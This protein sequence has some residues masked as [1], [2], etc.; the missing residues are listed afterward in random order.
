MLREAIFVV[1]GEDQ[2]TIDDD[3]KDPVGAFDEFGLDAVLA[4]DCVRQTDGRGQVVSHPAVFDA[5]LHADDSLSV[6]WKSLADF[7]RCI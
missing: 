6:G 5:D 1:L 3:V 7:L 2:I 4:F